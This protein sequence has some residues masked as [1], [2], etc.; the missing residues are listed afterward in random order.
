MGFDCVR[1][2]GLAKNAAHLHLIGLAYNMTRSLK[3][4]G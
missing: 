1:N 3:L 4:A 2:V